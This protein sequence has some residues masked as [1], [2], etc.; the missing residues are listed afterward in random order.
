MPGALAEAFG[1]RDAV[2][3]AALHFV[4]PQAKPR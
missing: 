1:E 2:V 3:T 4:Q